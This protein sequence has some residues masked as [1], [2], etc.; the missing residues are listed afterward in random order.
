MVTTS[1]CII[2]GKVH[3]VQ[4]TE[5]GTI[6]KCSNVKCYHLQEVCR[7]NRRNNQNSRRNGC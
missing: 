5:F 3:N 1:E 2:C 4:D 7:H 6:Y